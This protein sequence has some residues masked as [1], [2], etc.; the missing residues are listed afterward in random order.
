MEKVKI[1]LKKEN[2]LFKKEYPGQRVCK[3]EKLVL[4]KS[5]SSIYN[6]IYTGIVINKMNFTL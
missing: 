4:R 2:L 6:A 3:T 1:S 5:K